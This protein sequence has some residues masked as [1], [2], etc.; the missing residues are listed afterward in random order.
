MHYIVNKLHKSSFPIL[1]TTTYQQVPTSGRTPTVRSLTCES[2]GLSAKDDMSQIK[3]HCPVK[4]NI[5][6]HNNVFTEGEFAVHCKK[7]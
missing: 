7:K 5:A 4:N 3:L 1:F 2:Q 6:K